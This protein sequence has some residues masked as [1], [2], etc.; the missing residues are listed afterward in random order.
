M[1]LSMKTKPRYS[2]LHTRHKRSLCI[3][4]HIF[5]NSKTKPKTSFSQHQNNPDLKIHLIYVVYEQTQ[6]THYKF[7]RNLR[8]C[9]IERRN[10]L[11]VTRE[12]LSFLLNFTDRESVTFIPFKRSES[13]CFQSTVE[14]NKLA[15]LQQNQ[16]TKIERRSR[17][18]PI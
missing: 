12:K 15:H 6:C 4:V 16:A 18:R 14:K 8:P 7:I 10:I 1:K 11:Q 9:C 17:G 3:K 2:K 5:F 13:P